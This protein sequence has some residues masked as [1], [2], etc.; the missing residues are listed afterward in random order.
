MPVSTIAFDTT[1][2][3]TSASYLDLPLLI[4]LEGQLYTAIY[5][6]KTIS[7]NIPSSPAYGILRYA[8]ACP[9]FWGPGNFL[10]SL[11]NRDTSWNAWNRHSG[12]FMSM[13][14]SYI[15]TWSPP[16]TN[17][18]CHSDPRPNT[19][20]SQSITLFT[21]SMTLIPSLTFTE[22]RV[23]SMEDLQWVWHASRERLP[24]RTPGSVPFWGLGYVPI[25]ENSFSLTCR[26]SLGI[27]SILLWTTFAYIVTESLWFMPAGLHST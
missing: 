10:V 23:A 21:N 16:L 24:F 9:G 27:F 4:G 11:S 14:G 3:I 2:S 5:D 17:V 26:V 15:A 8:R 7:G 20:T 6:E 13:H 19:M 18:K 1:E 22:L 12:S 25:V